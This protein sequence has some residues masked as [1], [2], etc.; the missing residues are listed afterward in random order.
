MVVPHSYGLGVE[1]SRMQWRF[2]K[3][4]ATR[5]DFGHTAKWCENAYAGSRPGQRLEIVQCGFVCKKEMPQKNTILMRNLI[6]DHNYQF[7]GVMHS[8]QLP[9]VWRDNEKVSLSKVLG[10]TTTRL[11]KRLWLRLCMLVSCTL[12]QPMTITTRPAACSVCGEYAQ[13]CWNAMDWAQSCQVGVGRGIQ[14]SGKPRDSLFITSKVTCTMHSSSPI[15]DASRIRRSCGFC[16]LVFMDLIGFSQM[17][18]TTKQKQCPFYP[19]FMGKMYQ[20]WDVTELPSF[21]HKTWWLSPLSKDLQQNAQVPGC[22]LQNTTAKTVEQ[23]KTETDDKIA[24]D[25]QQLNLSYLDMVKALLAGS[26]DGCAWMP[27]APNGI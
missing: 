11:Q 25:L 17:R 12:I 6:V 15:W 7:W 5:N 19:I 8:H 3:P 13:I 4:T 14:K 24:L 2:S 21:S 26:C 18:K 16:C 9:C 1:I 10:S 27:M 22:G 20:P 23:C